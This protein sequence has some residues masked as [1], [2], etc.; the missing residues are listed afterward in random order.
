MD[1]KKRLNKCSYFVHSA[2]LEAFRHKCHYFVAVCTVL[3]I[4]LST[5][6]VQ[7]LIDRGPVIFL[8]M[9]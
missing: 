3:I 7:T 6:I 9:A 5:M 1:F 2:F 8:K 4:V